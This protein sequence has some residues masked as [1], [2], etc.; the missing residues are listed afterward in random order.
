MAIYTV[1]NNILDSSMSFPRQVQ[2]A[3]FSFWFVVP[4]INPVIHLAL[5]RPFSKLGLKSLPI[6]M[7]A[8]RQNKVYADEAM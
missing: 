1:V 4:A 3:S 8:R 6:V 2:L 5:H 7:T